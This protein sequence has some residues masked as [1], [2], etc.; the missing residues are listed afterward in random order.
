MK[1]LVCEGA[2]STDEDAVH[3]A[4]SFVREEVD[5]RLNER[6]FVYGCDVCGTTTTRRYGLETLHAWPTGA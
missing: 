4:H 2:C 5:A 6:A 3:T 1:E